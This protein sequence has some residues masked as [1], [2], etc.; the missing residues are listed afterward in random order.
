MNKLAEIA[1]VNFMKYKIVILFLL[2]SLFILGCETERESI[3]SWGEP[4][5]GLRCSIGIEE[6]RWSKGNPVLVS[7]IVENVSGSKVNLKMIPTFTLNETQYWCPVDIVG[8]EH[9]LPANARSTISLERGA[10]INSKIDI[11]KLGWDLCIS[12]MWPAQNLFS[13]VPPGLYILRLDI[14]V[15]NGGEPKW[16]HSN[17]VK[18]YISK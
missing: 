8:E 1:G 9:T 10:L 5:N 7:V 17:E 18:V 11:S 4:S 14:E 15:V 2:L 12:S 13:L 3:I 16:I 6:T